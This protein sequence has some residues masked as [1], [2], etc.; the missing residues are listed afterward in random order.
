LG[1]IDGAL[2]KP[3]LNLKKFQRSFFCDA[4][5]LLLNVTAQGHHPDWLMYQFFTYYSLNTHDA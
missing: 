1:F 2:E 3:L 4:R 5:A